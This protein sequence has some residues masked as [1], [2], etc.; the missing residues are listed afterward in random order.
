M[1]KLK[2]ISVVR[3]VIKQFNTK[4]TIEMLA[5][6]TAEAIN[7]VRIIPENDLQNIYKIKEEIIS[8]TEIVVSSRINVEECKQ[9]PT[10]LKLKMNG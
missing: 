1:N 8:N 9:I 6:N 7:I 2:T 4:Q 5:N 3:E 10:Q